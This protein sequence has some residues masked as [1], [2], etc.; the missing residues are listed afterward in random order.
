MVRNLGFFSSHRSPGEPAVTLGMTL[1]EICGAPIGEDVR[2][3]SPSIF[4]ALAR[5]RCSAA[6][7]ARRRRCS[8]QISL[9]RRIP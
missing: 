2:G 8:S 7:R 5:R 4:S 3:F 6:S 1:R 9:S